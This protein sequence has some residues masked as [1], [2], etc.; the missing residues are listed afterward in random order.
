MANKKT[1]TP[2]HSGFDAPVRGEIM[3]DGTQLKRRSD[4]T[5]YAVKPKKK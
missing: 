3:P 2:K 5:I 4:G 1:K